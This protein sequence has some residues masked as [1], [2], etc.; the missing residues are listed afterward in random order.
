MA[1]KQHEREYDLVVFGATGYTGQ[2]VAERITN[3]L[4]TNLIWAVAGRSKEKLES[5][6]ADL[7]ALNPDRI[8]PEIEIVD[9]NDEDFTALAK[10]TFILITTVGPYH[11][12]GEIAF[13]ACAQSGTHYLDVTGEP[14]WVAL[15]IKKYEE[16]AKKSGAMMFPQIGLDS[17]PADVMTWNLAKT[18]RDEL[19]A[20]TKDVTVSM[21]ELN[22]GASGGTL[23]TALTVMDSY[24]IKELMASLAPFA[25]SPVPQPYQPRQSV[26]G[27]LTGLYNVP[28]LGLQCTAPNERMD[29]SIVERSWGLLSVTPSR[30]NEAYGPKF[31]FREHMKAKNW[32]TGMAFHLTAFFVKIFVFGIPPMRRLVQRFV[33]QP[34]QGPDKEESRMKNSIEYRGVGNPDIGKETGKRAYCRAHFKGGIYDFTGLIISQAALILLEED[35]ELEG[36]IYTPSFLAKN[37]FIERMDKA[38]FKWETSVVDV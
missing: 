26:I 21:H 14:P 33:H 32:L 10:K 11:L 22:A 24:S 28:G 35:V 27:M 17:A 9:L 1:L 25:L 8:A 29:G 37:G 12:H 13:K 30:K 31:S 34:G 3:Q 20:K 38:G 23:T 4:P 7:K 18:I 19:D 36:G 2:Y 16:A 5:L 6:V 15:M